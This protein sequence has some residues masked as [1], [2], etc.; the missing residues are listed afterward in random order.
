MRIRQIIHT[1]LVGI[2]K[3][4]SHSGKEFG[5]F[6]KKKKKKK[7]QQ[8]YDL[9]AALLS[10]YLREVKICLHRNLHMNVY[11]SII[12]SNQKLGKKEKYLL[13]SD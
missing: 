8:P 5:S 12:H 3:C 1:L 4:N 11:S 6:L 2:K 10:I 13:M 9:A 7:T